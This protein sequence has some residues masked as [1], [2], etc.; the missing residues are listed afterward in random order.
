[1][2]TVF[3]TR[4]WLFKNSKYINILYIILL[5]KKNMLKSLNIWKR[6]NLRIEKIWNRH[7]VEKNTL[8]TSHKHRVHILKVSIKKKCF[9]LLFLLFNL[10]Y[11]FLLQEIT[12]F[13]SLYSS[14]S[15]FFLLFFF[16]FINVRIKIFMDGKMRHHV[17]IWLSKNSQINKSKELVRNTK[18]KTCVV[19]LRRNTLKHKILKRVKCRE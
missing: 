11:Y 16:Q 5:H 17:P 3:Q 4:S 10:F 2:T 14:A 6:V 18:Q 8:H 19:W 15:S 13:Y 7:S 1:M 12:H 9:Y